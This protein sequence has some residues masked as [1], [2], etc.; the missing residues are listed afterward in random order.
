MFCRN[1]QN[2]SMLSLHWG[3]IKNFLMRIFGYIF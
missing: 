1:D 3:L 2:L